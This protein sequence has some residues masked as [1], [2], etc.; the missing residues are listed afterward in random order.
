MADLDIKQWIFEFD[1]AA[2]DVLARR[3]DMP[4]AEVYRPE[5]RLCSAHGRSCVTVTLGEV[6]RHVNWTEVEPAELA[7]RILREA[8]PQ[9]S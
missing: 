5:A 1:T 3:T 9:P 8:L 2:L 4:Q 6:Q 7:E